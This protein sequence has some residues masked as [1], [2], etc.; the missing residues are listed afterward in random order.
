ML[1]YQGLHPPYDPNGFARIVT[2]DAG[3]KCA[4]LVKTGLKSM[5]VLGKST[6]GLA[7]LSKTFQTCSK[8]KNENEALEL[9]EW[10]ASA[11]DYLA[12]GDYPYPS[13][14]VQPDGALLPAYPVKAVCKVALMEKDPIQGLAAGINLFY[15][16]TKAKKCFFNN[17]SPKQ[18]QQLS[19]FSKRVM[20]SQRRLIVNTSSS[21]Q[22]E[23]TWDW[24]WCTEHNMPFTSG[25]DQDMFFPPTGPIDHVETAKSCKETWGVTP[26]PAWASLSYGGI[27][28]LKRGLNN[29]VFSNGL[30]DPWSAGGILDTE[31]FDPSVVAILIPN[32][33]HHLDL[34]FSNNVLD[35]LD[36][37]VARVK[38]LYHIEKWINQARRKNYPNDKKMDE[39][40]AVVQ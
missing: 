36:V 30:L 21:R 2:K 37:R 3:P 17:V 16:A 6:D 38:E 19:T 7:S 14:Y 9:I 23:G 35:P 28:G 31:G 27:E 25:T 12:M 4:N 40:F 10:V 32:G 15:N 8:L 11:F 5:F 20:G 29:V 13:T 26:N 1:A 39:T 18:Q 33:A 24:Q 34:M 22:C